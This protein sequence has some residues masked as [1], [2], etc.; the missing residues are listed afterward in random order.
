MTHTLLL[1]DRA[2][3]SWSMRIGLLVDHFNLPLDVRYT[4][5]YCD[6]FTEKL[7]DF[8]P[9]RTVP[10]LRLETG[11][12]VTESLA[13]AEEL[14]DRFPDKPLW[15]ANENS[16]AVARA[17]TAEMHAGFNA[18]RNYCPMNLR[19]AYR[20]VPVPEDVKADLERLDVIWTYTRATTAPSGPWLCGD[21]SIA[22]AFFAPVAARIAGYGLPVSE[23]AKDY[24]AAHLTHPGFQHWRKLALIEGPDQSFYDKPYPQVEWPEERKALTR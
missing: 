11:A 13:I 20:D 19:L 6:D 5:L 1:A 2:Y 7:S 17:I 23:S 14:A 12:V 9:A 18:L 24:V 15:P 4:Q 10:A 3:S 22:D 21:Y 16:R 8:D